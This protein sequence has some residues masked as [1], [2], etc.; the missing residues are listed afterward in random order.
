[1]RRFGGLGFARKQPLS[2]GVS[3]QGFLECLCG[4]LGGLLQCGLYGAELR[5]GSAAE[6][7]SVGISAAGRLLL[8]RRHF[9]GVASSGGGWRDR[10]RGGGSDGTD[11]FGDLFLL[12]LS[13]YR[14]DDEDL[15]LLISADKGVKGDRR[16][17]GR[18]G[19]R[20]GGVFRPALGGP[21]SLFNKSRAAFGQ[22]EI[23]SLTT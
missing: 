11:H 7:D 20:V 8:R 4:G 18:V 15:R 21:T 13:S 5:L 1:L 6:V 23:P 9:L 22:F 16:K 17:Y 2:H 10:L 3:T 14:Q 12:L 19:A